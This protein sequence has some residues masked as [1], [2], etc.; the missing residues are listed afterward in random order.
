MRDPG[1]RAGVGGLALVLTPIIAAHAPRL[2]HAAEAV[3]ATQPTEAAETKAAV[4]VKTTEPAP[5]SEKKTEGKLAWD[6]RWPRFRPIE[7]VVTGVG[8]PIAIGMYYL[9]KPQPT[10]NWIGGILIDDDVRDALRMRTNSGLK[11][12]RALSDAADTVLVVLVFGVDSVLV[13]VL[14]G[15]WD[16][17]FQVSLMDLESFMFSSVLTFTLYDTIGRARPSYVDCQHG[18]T[19]PQCNTSPTASFPSGH[20]NEAATAAG[21]SCAHHTNVPLYGARI[22][23]DLACARDAALATAGALFRIMG[24]RHYLTDVLAGGAIGF[25]FGYGLPNLLHY[26]IGDRHAGELTLAPMVG[27]RA[28]L[29]ASGTF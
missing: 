23:D 11:T 24:D 1:G 10:P 18:S 17:A 15:S 27:T 21:L 5:A 16:V 3:K 19:D 4:E 14:R 7:Y 13:P 20:V 2:A 25:A 29:V 26:T 8:G 9:L 22:W 12:V 6:P 28:G